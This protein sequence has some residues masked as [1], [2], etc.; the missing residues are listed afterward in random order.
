MSNDGNSGISPL[1]ATINS[2]ESPQFSF[3]S[4]HSQEYMSEFGCISRARTLFPDISIRYTPLKNY[5]GKN[6]KISLLLEI[7]EKESSFLYG[8]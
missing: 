2:G 5:L 6:P 7:G 4:T 3:E 8:E 1:H